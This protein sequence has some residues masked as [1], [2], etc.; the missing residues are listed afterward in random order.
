MKD[1][2]KL[3]ELMQRDMAA[4]EAKYLG[5]FAETPH[6]GLGN[7]KTRCVNEATLP[8]ITCHPSCLEKCAGTCY[9]INICTKLRPNCR[10]VEAKNTVLRQIDPNAYYEH[11]YKETERLHL[12]IRLSDGGDFENVEQVEACKAAARRHPT[13]HAILYTK[14]LELLLA[15][16]ER[17]ANLYVRYSAWK[18]DEAGEAEARRLGFDVTHVVWD[19]SGNC[20]YQKSLARFLTRKHEIAR[21]LRAQGIDAKT[22]NKRA[23]REKSPFGIAGTARSTVVAVAARATSASMSLVETIGPSRPRRRQRRY[24]HEGFDRVVFLS[25][26]RARGR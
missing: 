10:K 23:E 17:P 8:I 25:S 2:T 1:F 4:F 19:G 22:A 24:P 12:P 15:F 5:R 7:R 6:V 14:R 18:G 11:F 20:P 9:V 3:I 16:V 21:T 13:V 26:G